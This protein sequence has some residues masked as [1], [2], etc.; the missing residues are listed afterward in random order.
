MYFHLFLTYIVPVVS[1]FEKL[2]ENKVNE[3]YSLFDNLYKGYNSD[4][5]VFFKNNTTPYI[6]SFINN[7]HN[8]GVIVWKYSRYHN[9]FYNYT[10]LYKDVKRFPI[11]SAVI[12][13]VKDDNETTVEIAC[14]DDFFNNLCVEQANIEF[15]T[16]QQIIGVWSYS[17]GLVLDRTKTYLMKY[18]D[19]NLEEHKKNIFTENFTF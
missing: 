18:L 1:F 2:Y 8:N 10:C 4:V 3:L 12:E 9:M 17:N 11:I 19:D 5:L 14:L 15:P 13:E 7:N 16:L 6:Y